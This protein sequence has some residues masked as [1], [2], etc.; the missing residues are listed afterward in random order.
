MG[1]GVIDIGESI[2][3]AAEV[4]HGSC[5]DLPPTAE[6]VAVTGDNAAALVFYERL[7][8]KKSA[9]VLRRFGTGK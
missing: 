9:M 4:A 2:G 1:W 8:F 7:R 6:K 5:A 3:M